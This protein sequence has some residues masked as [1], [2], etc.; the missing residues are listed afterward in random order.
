MAQAAHMYSWHDIPINVVWSY[1]LAQRASSQ[2][3]GLMITFPSGNWKDFT[4][5][6]VRLCV[7]GQD[8]SACA[9]MKEDN[10]QLDITCVQARDRYDCLQKVMNKE[11]NV[12]RG[13]AADV[14]LAKELFEADLSVV[15]STRAE[16]MMDEPYRYR[17]VAVVR[18][19]S[20]KGL[21]DLKGSKSCHTGYGRTVGWHVPFSQLLQLYKLQISCKGDIFL[22]NSGYFSSLTT[23]LGTMTN[24]KL[25]ADYN[26]LCNLCGNPNDCGEQDLHAGYQGALRCLLDSY[27]DV[28]WTKLDVID[29][30]FKSR[31]AFRGPK[32]L[33]VNSSDFG[34]LCRDGRI[35]DLDSVD[36]CHW[37]ARPWPAWL[38]RANEE[39]KAAIVSAISDAMSAAMP[40]VKE[41]DDP[42]KSPPKNWAKAVLG[43]KGR[44]II[45]DVNPPLSPYK[46]LNQAGYDTTI[47]R[48]G[49]KE[50]PVRLCVD[51][52]VAMQKCKA[53]GKVL[54]SRRVR[55]P[56]ACVFPNKPDD[57]V[58]GV[59]NGD[60]DFATVDGGDMFR[61]HREYGILPVVGERYGV[62]DA[63]YFAV[64]VVRADSGINSL[65]DLK[66]KK[67][68]HTGIEKTS[69]WKIPV[70]TLL[71]A[72]LLKSGDCDYA[73]QIGNFF[74][75]SCA[76]GSK[77]PKYDH[78]GTNPASLCKL[79]VGNEVSGASGPLYTHTDVS[80]KCARDPNEAYYS[81]TGAFR[82]LVEGGG[83]VAFVKHTTVTENTNGNSNH[84][85]SKN[86]KA[87]D[88]RL[89]CKNHG[90]REVF[91]YGSCHF[92]RVPSHKVITGPKSDDVLQEEIRILM[93]RASET[94]PQGQ[95]AFVMFGDYG[96]YH[97]IIFKSSTTSL[98]NLRDD[99]F[100]KSLDSLYFRALT[101]LD[102]CRP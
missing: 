12:A 63:S 28:A 91:E 1:M 72:G 55:P 8:S 96:Q 4:T 36:A 62:N 32:D 93:L 98:V 73:K 24:G 48:L 40:G 78:H 61:G 82:C 71:E 68:C 95:D 67:S 99:E 94:L 77:L 42:A 86:L 81:Y 101:E 58:A 33:T 51:S 90:T 25:K 50:D 57:C 52:D 80:N 56:L 31:P 79:C 3:V 2:I 83:D 43:I 10:P 60:A 85:W 20:I 74:S 35:L 76:P 88:F 18:R 27:G 21:K 34:L 64:A 45:K 102:S 65:A 16:D 41:G 46:Y 87:S 29:D 6:A 7:T 53:L 23:I 70:V 15:A 11:A 5:F 49:C 30:F 13:D 14:Y 54:K 19:S 44:S 38:T 84:T 37:A 100:H 47:S 22:K 17:G 9:M 97:D 66:G 69:G 75:E 26:N 92:A 39:N 59:A 89:L